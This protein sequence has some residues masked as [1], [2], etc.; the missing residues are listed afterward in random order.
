MG[1]VPTARCVPRCVQ[2]TEVTESSGPRSHSFVTL[3]VHALHR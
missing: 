1:V 2:L 3:E